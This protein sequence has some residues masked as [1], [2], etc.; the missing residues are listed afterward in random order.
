MVGCVA[1]RDGRILAEGFHSEAGA[2]HA[3][4]EAI[5]A[6]AD[7]IA[8]AT[9][10][11]T[12]EPCNHTGRT[13]P[14]TD[15]LIAEGPNRIVIAMK[16]PNPRVSGQGLAAL[17]EAG[18]QV[19]V[20][21]LESEARAL[22]E[23]YIK[24]ITGK[25]PFVIAKCAMSVDG[26]IATRT[27]DSRWVTGEASR[28]RVHE[29]RDEVDAILVG[30]RTVMTDD[31]SLTTRLPQGRGHDPVRILVDADDYLDASHRVFHLDSPAPTWVVVPIGRGFEG[32]AE[33]IQVPTGPGGVDM[34]ELMRELAA[35]EIVSVLIEGGGAT[36]ASAFEARIVDKIMFFIAP[37]IVGGHDAVTAVEGVGA[38]RMDD[39][40]QLEH[41]TANPVGEDIL[42]EAYVKKD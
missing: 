7:G 15:R 29:I 6:A 25:Q 13:P 34:A 10:Y 27:G 37:K 38:E 41:M 1:V 8:G 28:A 24:F 9:L 16:D 14:C 30:S 22:N 26:K 32:E 2:P 33:V 17:R 36:L 11:V 42:I 31:P 20:G 3:E 40:I 21:V 18:I 23:A 19:D 12:L 39:A 4:I 35:R 5:D